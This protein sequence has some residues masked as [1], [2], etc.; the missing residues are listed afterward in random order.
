MVNF[1]SVV[2]EEAELL[3]QELSQLPPSHKLVS[4]NKSHFQ[5]IMYFCNN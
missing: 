3:L 5:K 4:E 1:K 2:I